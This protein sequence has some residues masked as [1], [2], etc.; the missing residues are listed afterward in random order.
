[1][2][3]LVDRTSYLK[4]CEKLY[5]VILLDIPKSSELVKFI[6]IEFL[7]N[8]FSSERY[9]NHLLANIPEIVLSS[10]TQKVDFMSACESPKKELDF[11]E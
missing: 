7:W 9:D 2:L 8:K 5:C 11:A 1:M 6:R 4:Y 10:T 3:F